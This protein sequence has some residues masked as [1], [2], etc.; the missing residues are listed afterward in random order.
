MNCQETLD[1]NAPAFNLSDKN[2]ENL[3][4]K[5]EDFEPHTWEN[6]RGIIGGSASCLLRQ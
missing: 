5:D 2:H 4:R 6:L 1:E 3:A